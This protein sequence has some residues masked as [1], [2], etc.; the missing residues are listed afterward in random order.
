MCLT[1]PPLDFDDINVLKNQLD[2]IIF[3]HVCRT[4]D[5]NLYQDFVSERTNKA[6]KF[7]KGSLSFK[8]ESKDYQILNTLRR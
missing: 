6:V 8:T 2:M 4:I 7:T 1:L 5:K 3:V